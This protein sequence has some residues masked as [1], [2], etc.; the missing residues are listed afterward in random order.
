MEMQRGY[1]FVPGKVFSGINSD[2]C[3][4]LLESRMEI[5]NRNDLFHYRKEIFVTSYL[6][7]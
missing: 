5:S 7:K 4:A 2:F 3:R 6:Q 1:N